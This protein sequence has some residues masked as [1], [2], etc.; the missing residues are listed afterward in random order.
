MIE[1]CYASLH[2]DDVMINFWQEGRKVVYS[3]GLC[4]KEMNKGM[5]HWSLGGLVFIGNK[6]VV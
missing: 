3:F 6:G 2:D 5:E 4:K 1:L